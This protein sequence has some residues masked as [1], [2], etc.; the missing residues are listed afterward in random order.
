M[1]T[2]T[3]DAGAEGALTPVEVD[4][5]DA[6]ADD[7]GAAPWDTFEAL[8]AP[9]SIA[10]T[11]ALVLIFAYLN[12]GIRLLTFVDLRVIKGLSVETQSLGDEAIESS[13]Q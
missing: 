13:W 5:V 4:V 6:A 1:V 10:A 9:R 2:F 11:A 12:L 8:Q 7:V 3:E